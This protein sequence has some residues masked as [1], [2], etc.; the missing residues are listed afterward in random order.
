MYNT[1][2]SQAVTHPSTNPA[3]PGLT[4]V[5]GREPVYSRWYGHRRK[6]AMVIW[7]FIRGFPSPDPQ[8]ASVWPMSHGMCIADTLQASREQCCLATCPA[9]DQAFR[10]A[11]RTATEAWGSAPP[12]AGGR[13]VGRAASAAKNQYRFS[14]FWLRSSVV[15]TSLVSLAW[16]SSVTTKLS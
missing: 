11:A 13:Q 8:A 14:A 3:R 10:Q 4:P 7:P 12:N 15:Y 5:I 1:G 2:Y 9:G 16:K 6:N